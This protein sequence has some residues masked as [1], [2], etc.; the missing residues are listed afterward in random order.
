VNGEREEERA[1]WLDGY[2]NSIG[3]KMEGEN[4]ELE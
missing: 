4:N 1:V 2:L 3:E